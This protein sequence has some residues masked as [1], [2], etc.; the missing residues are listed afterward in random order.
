M[1]PPNAPSPEQLQASRQR[2]SDLLTLRMTRVVLEGCRLTQLDELTDAVE[3]PPDVQ[4]EKCTATSPTT[5]AKPVS[6][7][8][9]DVYKRQL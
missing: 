7:T 1:P 3:S 9:L 8:H 2:A 6:Y 5:G 4:V